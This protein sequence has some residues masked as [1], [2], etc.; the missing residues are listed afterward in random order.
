MEL[1]F[2]AKTWQQMAKRSIVVYVM[3][4]KKKVCVDT[5]NSVSPIAV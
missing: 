1:D 4:P 5:W 3:K 2:Q